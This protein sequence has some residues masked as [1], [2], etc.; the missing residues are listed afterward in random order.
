MK[1]NVYVKNSFLIVLA[2]CSIYYIRIVATTVRI[3]FLNLL[4]FGL[5]PAVCVFVL[6]TT[7]I[8]DPQQVALCLSFM[9]G[10]L[11]LLG[12]T[13]FS[14]FLNH[15]GLINAVSSFMML[16]EPFMFLLAMTCLPVSTQILTKMKTFLY[17][18]VLINFL[19]AAVQKPLIN[20][21]KIYAQG[22]DGT[23]GCGGVFFV[24]IAGGY[25]SAS[26]SLVFAL[27][28]F[29]DRT[30]PFWLRI[31]VSLAA[32]WQLL[33][34]D[35]KQLLAAYGFA[36]LILIIF[37]SKDIF[38][39]LK[40][41]IGLV[42]VVSIGVW[43]ANNIDEFRAYTSWARPELYGPNGEAWHSKFFAA[44]LILSRTESPLNWL[45]GLG[46]GHTVSRLGG[47]FIK[48]YAAILGPLGSTTTNIGQLT[49]EFSQT[50]WL[51]GGSTMFS[52][53]WGWVGIWGDLG[54]LGLGTYLYLAYLTWRHFCW[55]DIMKVT[56]L[57]VFVLGFIFTQ[58]EE[59]GYMIF[60]A[61][62][63]GLSWQE[64]QLQKQASRRIFE[65]IE[66]LQ[67]DR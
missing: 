5:V 51:T 57:N 11:M 50:F 52:P 62:M 34:S 13:V 3:P 22:L 64:R 2:F 9:T 24:S 17:W 63:L 40:L 48:D 36:W 33:F 27:Y 16:G 53:F 47:W 66:G 20:A 8:R 18:S 37:T 42:L 26:V 58:M 67:L 38:K 6:S 21:G 56:I 28:F 61:F 44:R 25:V 12:V 60:I 55:N 43:C 15:A 39:T 30:K 14:A 31:L 29:R 1:F 45:L 32:L 10:L 19:L 41:I 59:P 65:G 23:D 54:F 7:R 49:T 46:P 4:H 35:S